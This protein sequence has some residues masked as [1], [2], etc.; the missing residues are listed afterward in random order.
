MKSGELNEIL[1]QRDQILR[2]SE[3]ETESLQFRNQQ[4]AK[5]VEILQDELERANLKESSGK[6]SAHH[7]HIRDQSKVAFYLSCL[8][9]SL[10]IWC[11]CLKL[12]LFPLMVG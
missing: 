9:K 1:R 2:K 8:N 11:Q 10:S 6:K 3:S 5:R 7:D 12:F 4:L